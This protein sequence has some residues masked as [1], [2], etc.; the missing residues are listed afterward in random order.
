M[1]LDLASAIATFEDKEFIAGT[2]AALAGGT[3]KVS[4]IIKRLF[5]TYVPTAAVGSPTDGAYQSITYVAGEEFE[6][7]KQAEQSCRDYGQEGVEL[8][9]LTSNKGYRILSQ[10]YDTA[11]NPLF[12]RDPSGN[13]PA[14]LNGYRVVATANVPS[15]LGTSSDETLAILGPFSTQAVIGTLADL[16]V[17]RTDAHQFDK[18]M[19]SIFLQERADFAVGKTAGF[20]AITAIK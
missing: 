13:G 18:N 17:N 9:W 6:A 5:P 11:G 7:V 20:C 15:N 1:V 4:G 19:W 14:T 12:Q 10:A 2:G 8:V 3:Y 16:T